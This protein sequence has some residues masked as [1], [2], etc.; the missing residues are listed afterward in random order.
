MSRRLQWDHV[1]TDYY[2]CGSFEIF[3]QYDGW[4]GYRWQLRVN[5]RPLATSRRLYLVKRYA[6]TLAETVEVGSWTR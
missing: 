2:R 4:R 3:R 6:L 1:S 5:G